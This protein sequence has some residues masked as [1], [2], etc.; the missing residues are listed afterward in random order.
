MSAVVDAIP[1]A[2]H[3]SMTVRKKE[4]YF[5]ILIRGQKYSFMQTMSVIHT[6]DNPYSIVYWTFSLVHTRDKPY[7][8]IHTQDKAYSTIHTRHTSQFHSH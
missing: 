4:I 3:T 6:G 1:I 8:I 5:L 2:I 7:R